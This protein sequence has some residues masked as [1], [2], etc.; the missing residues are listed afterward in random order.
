MK[1]ILQIKILILFL[2]GMV[3]SFLYSSV[4]NNNTG[5][6]YL[7][8]PPDTNII[9]VK[10]FHPLLFSGIPAFDRFEIGIKVPQSIKQKI[11]NFLNNSPGLN[12][13]NPDDIKIQCE[14]TLEQ[15]NKFFIRNGFFYKEFTALNNLWT[16]QT[17]DFSYRVR[18]APP[19]AGHYKC[20]VSISVK[21]ILT[22]YYSNFEFDV[23]KSNNPGYLVIGSVNS[24]KMRFESGVSFFAV[25][26]DIAFADQ[27]MGL[28]NPNFTKPPLNYPDAMSSPNTHNIQRGYIKDLADHDGNFVRIRFDPWSV[29][30]V[31]PNKTIP[32]PYGA[33]NR[34]I[35]L[36]NYDHNQMFM[37]EMDST[38]ALCE[39]RGVYLMLCI[40]LEDAINN[41]FSGDNNWKKNPYNSILTTDIQGLKNFFSDPTAKLYFKRQLYYIQA[42]WGY[43]TNI[44]IWELINETQGIGEYRTDP[45]DGSTRKQPYIE[46]EVFRGHVNDWIC[47][48]KAYLKN[49]FYPSQLITCGF[50]PDYWE[51][52]KVRFSTIDFQPPC[53]DIFSENH[54]SFFISNKGKYSDANEG[55]FNIAK[56]YHDKMWPF[57]FGEIGMG[58]VQI[59]YLSDRPYHNSVWATCMMGGIGC[60]LN[61]HDWR[62]NFNTSHRSN[63]NALRTFFGDVVKL[64]ER[65]EPF[66]YSDKDQ[67]FNPGITKYINNYYMLSDSR[68]YG[69]GW[70]QN[71]GGNWTLDWENFPQ[72]GSTN[73][74]DSMLEVSG[75]DGKVEG[76]D[77]HSTMQDPAIVI[78]GLLKSKKYRIKIYDTHDNAKMLE[79]FTERTNLAGKLTFKR[80]MPKNIESPFYPDYAY[81]IEY[82]HWMDI[83]LYPNPA[84]D[85]VHIDYD[86]KEYENLSFSVVDI[87]G[88]TVSAV[89]IDNVI[90]TELLTDG[91]Y[92]LKV[93]SDDGSGGFKILVKHQ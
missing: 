16:E 55:R 20:K 63:F 61:C 14:Y 2:F 64:T 50:Q 3:S 46:D 83:H 93:K 77:C 78:K 66:F 52:G 10:S 1:F 36:N 53:L 69:I 82:I 85:V 58:A 35:A 86:P 40:L 42:R 65:M 39:S 9:S 8:S 81:T 22:G 88:Q 51:N 28:S 57:I 60:G 11:D 23:I 48:M 59:D 73:L 56:K 26:E 4:E 71:N 21:G 7:L 92:F 49:N 84:D 41:A 47:E 19:E 37:R 76:Y 6:Y 15:Q 89:I 75:F 5:N 18:F 70:A 45:T 32:D 34:S 27:D 87:L 24:S 25:G 67:W 90:H 31:A 54:Y 79:Q 12:P 72:S 44:G 43:S 68:K 74:K 17:T 30:I 62:Q 13:Y 33:Q 80:Y 91:I 29:P 38:L